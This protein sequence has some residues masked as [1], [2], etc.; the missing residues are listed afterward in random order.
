MR[1][2]LVSRSS[3]PL[4]RQIGKARSD[5]IRPIARAVRT[6]EGDGEESQIC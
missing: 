5:L 1:D 4:A 2:L 6:G 3:F